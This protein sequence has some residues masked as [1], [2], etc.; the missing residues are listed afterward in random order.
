MIAEMLSIFATAGT[1]PGLPLRSAPGLSMLS[2]TFGPLGTGCQGQ[3][4]V[5]PEGG[6]KPGPRGEVG[7]GIFQV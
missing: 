5:A 7:T 4:A 1:F 6:D 3:R 2:S